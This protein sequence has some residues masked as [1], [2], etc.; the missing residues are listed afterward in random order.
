ME[1]VNDQKILEMNV[2]LN[3]LKKE[4]IDEYKLQ[5]FQDKFRELGFIHY[6]LLP[7]EL[8]RL[9][10]IDK[11]GSSYRFNGLPTHIHVMERALKRCQERVKGWGKKNIRVDEDNVPVANCEPITEEYC[12]KY[13]KKLG[14]KVMKPKPV[15]YEEL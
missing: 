3:N 11:I 7:M 10:Q 13:L 14:Y 1:K 15:E 8:V 6:S 12:V 5:E 4:M 9:G 2:A